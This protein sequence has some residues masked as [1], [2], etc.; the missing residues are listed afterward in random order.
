MTGSA[1]HGGRRRR[2]SAPYRAGLSSR[3]SLAGGEPSAASDA[4]QHEA[5]RAIVLRQLAASAKSRRQLEEKLAA[6]DIPAGVAHEVLDRFEEVNL[7]D[8]RAFAAM[9]VRSRAET[10]RLSRSALRRE[11]SQRGITGDLAEEA[12]AQRSDEDEARDAHE[13]VR[14]KLPAQ[15]DPGDRKEYEKLTRRLVSMLGRKGYPPGTAFAVV[16]AE[17]SAPGSVTDTDGAAADTMGAEVWD[18]P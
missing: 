11:L 14:K 15:V 6:R 4:D 12:L 9:F 7:V 10:R 18:T 16:K 2:S 3:D 1:P 5:A 17:L 13:L 8:D